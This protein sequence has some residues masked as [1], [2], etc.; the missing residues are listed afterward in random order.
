MKNILMISLLIVGLMIGYSAA[1]HI[2][3]NVEIHSNY[4]RIYE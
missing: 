1:E 3:D 2:E 4:N